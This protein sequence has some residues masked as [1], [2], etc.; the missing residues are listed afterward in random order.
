MNRIKSTREEYEE[1]KNEVVAVAELFAE[2][3]PSEQN[4][5][6]FRAAI[7]RS[8]LRHTEG[9]TQAYYSEKLRRRMFGTN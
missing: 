1:Y 7:W 6:L 4:H 5:D 2:L 8:K 9:E 3:D